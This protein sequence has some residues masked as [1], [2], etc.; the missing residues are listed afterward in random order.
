MI[1]PGFFKDGCAFIRAHLVLSELPLDAVV[2]FLVD[3]G[4]SKTVISDKDAIFLKVDYEKLKPSSQKLS[5]VGGSVDTY[6]FED[7][8]LVFKTEADKLE[9]KFPILFLKHDLTSMNE[10]DRIKI[11][12]IPSLLGRDILNR[13]KLIYNPSENKLELEM[14]QRGADNKSLF[15]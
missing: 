13:F 1:V 14:K 7:T 15:I 9:F 2:N 12:R 10:E 8:T 6:I 11:L 3:T 4:A 5:G